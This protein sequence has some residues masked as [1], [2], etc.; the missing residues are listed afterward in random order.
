MKILSILATFSVVG[1]FCFFASGC[2]NCDGQDREFAAQTRTAKR[3]CRINLCFA[4]DGSSTIERK[5]YSNQKTVVQTVVQKTSTGFN[6]K[7]MGLA[8][9]QYATSN[10]AISPLTTNRQAFL[11]AVS[12]STQS[13]G[14]GS[15]ITGGLNYCFAQ[16]FQEKGRTNKIVLFTDGRADIGS[17][18][19]ERARLFRSIGG[20][21]FAVGVGSSRNSRVLQRITGAK[22]GTVFSL[23]SRNVLSVSN[24]LANSLCK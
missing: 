18:V 3:N 7:G 23:G 8:A 1:F 17:S 24:Q 22:R 14:R 6:S 4:L 5:M 12:S 20:E 19:A 11:S 2:E 13:M 15:F 10:Q 21:V 16:L 9:V